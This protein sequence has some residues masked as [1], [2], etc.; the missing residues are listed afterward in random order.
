MLCRGGELRVVTARQEQP[1][2]WL[3]SQ[4]LAEHAADASRGTKDDVH[5]GGEEESARLLVC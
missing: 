1:R 4:L 3:R 5:C 2:A